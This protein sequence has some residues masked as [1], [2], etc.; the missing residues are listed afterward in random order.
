MAAMEEL[1]LRGQV[2]RAALALVVL[3]GRLGAV[4]EQVAM[5]MAATAQTAA[6][7]A[8]HLPQGS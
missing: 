5:L 1:A 3:L 6:A 8:L 7:A 4:A 2:A